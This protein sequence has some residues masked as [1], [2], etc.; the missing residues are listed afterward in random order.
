MIQKSSELDFDH[1][2]ERVNLLNPALKFT[3]EKEQKNSLHFLDVLVETEGT[4]FLTRVYRKPE[5]TGNQRL[6][7][8]TSV[9]IHLTQRQERL[10]LLKL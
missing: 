1:F 4:R 2:Q 10:A 7:V 3:I 8:N 6:L 9:E 5:F